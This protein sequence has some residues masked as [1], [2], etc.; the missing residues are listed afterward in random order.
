MMLA[1][2]QT[3]LSKHVHA[4]TA[5]PTPEPEV[6]TAELENVP[7]A[8]A[9]HEGDTSDDDKAENV[10]ES[11]EQLF[12]FTVV[13]KVCNIYQDS[14]DLFLQTTKECLT[15]GEVRLSSLI[16]GGPIQKT[17][18]TVTVN[19]VDV[20]DT[21]LSINAP[22]DLAVNENSTDLTGL[23]QLG[24]NTSEVG[25]VAV[26]Y[27]LVGNSDYV[28]VTDAGI[29][30]LKQAFDYELLTADQRL[31]GVTVQAQA[32]MRRG[33]E[34][35]TSAA[36]AITIRVTDLHYPITVE[37]AAEK[38]YKVSQFEAKGGVISFEETIYNPNPATRYMSMSVWKDDY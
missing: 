24:H 31:N 37:A 19:V 18:Q 8:E 17:P 7:E 4:T 38:I 13:S 12:T 34:M 36:Q 22:D 3:F 27:G 26:S 11:D 14:A 21:P 33:Q 30:R 15:L 16:L 23:A 9:T 2:S 20:N 25:A 35:I 32:V 6:N 1:G 5:E 29:V 28:E 10:P